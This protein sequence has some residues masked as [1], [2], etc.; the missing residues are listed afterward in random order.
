MEGIRISHRVLK[1]SNG[2]LEC[3]MSK[4]GD[5]Q[6][7]LFALSPRRVRLCDVNL[8]DI[9]LSSHINQ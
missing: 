6:V 7:E 4:V 5:C 3:V 1:N 2:I 8:C 9:E